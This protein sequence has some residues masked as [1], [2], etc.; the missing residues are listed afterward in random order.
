MTLIELQLEQ[1]YNFAFFGSFLAIFFT[2]IILGAFAKFRKKFPGAQ[3]LGCIGFVIVFVIFT[4]TAPC[5]VQDPVK[6]T[7]AAVKFNIHSIHI[8]LERY[9]VDQGGFFPDNIQILIDENYLPEFPINPFTEQ[10]MREIEFGDEPYDGEFTYIP[11]TTEGVVSGY[12]LMCYGYSETEGHDV[13]GDG[14]PDHVILVI[15]SPLILG[16][17]ILPEIREL[18]EE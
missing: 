7:E 11:V 16:Y 8:A 5:W 4:M 13:N 17:S 10:P 12:Y 15:E 1:F 2:L 3:T 18:L 14:V 9:G 6:A